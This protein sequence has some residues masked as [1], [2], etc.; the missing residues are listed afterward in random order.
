[1]LH[2]EPRVELDE[3]ERAVRA[4]EELECAGIEVADGAA[5]SLGGVLHRLPLLGR[6]RR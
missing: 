5:R 3:V 2:L 4:D 1:M 6:E